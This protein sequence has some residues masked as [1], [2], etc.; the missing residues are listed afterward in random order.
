[1]LKF[2]DYVEYKL[3]SCATGEGFVIGIMEYSND[4]SVIC[5]ADNDYIGMPIN[6]V[7]LSKP[8][9]S[10]VKLAQDLR[11]RYLSKFPNTFKPNQ[12]QSHD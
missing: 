9:L 8:I 10:N 2:G 1:M 12:E 7:H 11:T 6:T 4:N 3:D 5:L